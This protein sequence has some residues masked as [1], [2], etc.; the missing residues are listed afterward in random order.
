MDGEG[1]RARSIGFARLTELPLEDVRA[2]LNEP[3]NH[4][5]M[6]LATVFSEED[7]ARWVHD[8][9]VQWEQHGFGPE[10]VLVD[11][12]LAGWG[13]FQREDAGA[14][15]SLVLAPRFWGHGAEVARRFV[16]RGFGELGLE[17]IVVSLPFSRS[18]ARALAPYGFRDQGTVTHGSVTFR[19]FRLRRADWAGSGARP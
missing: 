13:G 3:R 19:L 5:H 6:P 4:R 12:G 15:L 1:S 14:D 9:D 16:D 11:G 2:L 17:E 7:T 10:A 18:P 8:K